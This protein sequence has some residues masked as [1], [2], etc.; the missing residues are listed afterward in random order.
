V[1]VQ[2]LAA[3]ALVLAAFAWLARHFARELRA[4]MRNDGGA[5]AKCGF[6]ARSRSE[7]STAEARRAAG[8]MPIVDRRT[9]ASPPKR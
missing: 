4:F 9:H 7:I 5:C 6:A 3:F 1:S 8:I 2:Q